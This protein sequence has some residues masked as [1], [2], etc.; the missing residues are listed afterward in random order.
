MKNQLRRERQEERRKMLQRVVT[1]KTDDSGNGNNAM[2]RWRKVLEASSPLTPTVPGQIDA[3]DEDK[4]QARKELL[5]RIMKKALRKGS[6]TSED[7][8]HP[9]DD[10]DET[11]TEQHESLP[12]DQ[13]VES[14]KSTLKH[15][16]SNKNLLDDK[17]TGP[18]KLRKSSFARMREIVDVATKKDGRSRSDKNKSSCERE[19]SLSNTIDDDHDEDYKARIVSER[20]SL[21]RQQ[22]LREAD[23]APAA[24]TEKEDVNYEI[25]NEKNK[26]MEKKAKL[27]I[28]TEVE[29]EVFKFDKETVRRREKQNN[30]NSDDDNTSYKDKDASSLVEPA[31]VTPDSNAGQGNTPKKQSSTET[32]NLQKNPTNRRNSSRD[33]KESNK[34]K[35]EATSTGST[36]STAS[37]NT[38]S[39]A[40]PILKRESK[41]DKTESEEDSIKPM[42]KLNSFLALVREAVQAKKQEQATQ[43]PSPGSDV[44]SRVKEFIDDSIST[45]DG[46]INRTTEPRNPQAP[47][48]GSSKRK[49]RVMTEPPPKPKR[50]DSQASIWSENIPVITISKTE[51]DECILE[52]R[53]DDDAKRDKT[54]QDEHPAEDDANV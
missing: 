5:A 48:R 4:I 38:G 13:E 17:K 43:V 33:K 16:D 20:R 26:A 24:I 21:R 37:R 45:S 6:N 51:S 29:P 9:G 18:N 42:K 46:S 50:E 19:E 15:K 8:S 49:R 44:T 30:E 28:K 10:D 52:Q 12:H 34:D 25:I 14:N 11:D 1:A 3:P 36:T 35:E 31:A 39:G 41:Q 2:D 23:A 7:E 40:R 53:T 47:R 27:K 54:P 22:S 32:L